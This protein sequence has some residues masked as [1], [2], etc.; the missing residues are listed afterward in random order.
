MLAIPLDTTRSTQISELY[1]NAPYFGLMDTETGYIR[2]VENDELGN[3]PKI[4]PFLKENGADATIF[5]HMG[6]GVYNAFV[7][8]DMGVYKA[9]SNR[10][11]LDDIYT[12]Y[13]ADGITMIDSENCETLLDPGDTGSCKCGC[14]A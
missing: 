4:A 11:T 13:L 1:G 12:G 7:K 3:G 5:F 10:M 8:A 14:N 9:S 6:E 2:V